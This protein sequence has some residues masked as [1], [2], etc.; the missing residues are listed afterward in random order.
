MA[1]PQR[2]NGGAGGGAGAGA[3]FNFAPASSRDKT[4]YGSSMPGKENQH[5]G[6]RRAGQATMQH[7]GCAPT[8]T[9]LL[10]VLHTAAP[11]ATQNDFRST[12]TPTRTFAP[13]A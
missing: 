10:G 8:A 5:I 3:P 4:V 11:A 13:L 2:P 7:L 6:E 9:R 12:S 1:D